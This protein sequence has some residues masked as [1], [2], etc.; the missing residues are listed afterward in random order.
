MWKKNESPSPPISRA[1]PTPPRSQDL[2]ARTARIGSTLSVKGDVTGDEDLVIEGRV[3]GNIS[4]RKHSVTVGESGNVEADIT[5]RS[6]RVAG[7]VKGN[8]SGEELVVLLKTGRVEGN[9]A[10]A[11]VTLE[12][13][14]TFKGSIDMDTSGV[15]HQRSRKS[16]MSSET[17][18]TSPPSKPDGASAP[19]RSGTSKNYGLPTSPR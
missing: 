6:I 17:S 10:A 13:G 5:A 11:S 9:I 2:S 1:E 16:E 7:I 4:L 15:S 8:L 14:A 18:P 19:N 3:K 12:N